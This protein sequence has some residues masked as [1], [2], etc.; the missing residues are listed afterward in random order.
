MLAGTT[1]TVA[2]LTP[3]NWSHIKNTPFGIGLL[4]LDKREVPCELLANSK[5][6]IKV[7]VDSFTRRL[8]IVV[9]ISLARW[10]LSLFVR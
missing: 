4:R 7:S 6:V 9:Q 10:Q 1:Q 8:D 2:A 5:I 3:D